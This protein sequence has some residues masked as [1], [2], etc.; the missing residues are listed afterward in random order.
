MSG[1][2]IDGAWVE[3]GGPEL[4]SVDPAT[5]ISVWSDRSATKA[6]VELA[7]RAAREA[8]EGWRTKPFEERVAVAREFGRLVEESR[9]TVS[10]LISVETGKPRWESLTEV[11]SMVA[12]VDVSIASYR[13]RTGTRETE[14][15]GFRSVVRH[16]PHGVMG[17]LGP[18]NFPGHLP[19]GHIVPALLA[20][21]TVV[22]KPSEHVPATAIA[23]VE[24][25]EQAG[26]PPGVLN[27]VV[28]GRD[29]GASLVD[30]PYLDGLL[31]TGSAAVGHRLHR[32][33]AHRPETIL[34]LEM[35]GNNPLV[36]DEIEAVEAGLSIVLQSAY[37]TAGQRCT[38][39][40]RLLVPR[41]PFGSRFIDELVEATRRLR[42]G[43]FDDSAEPFMG[44]VI[45]SAA[46]DQLVEA[47]AGL[48]RL[49]AVPMLEMR[50]LREGTGFVS[51]A[52]IDVSAVSSL[53]DE[54][55]FGPLLQV[56]Y[57]D[58]FEEAIR[59]SNETRF[60][61]AAGLVSHDRTKWEAFLASVR[62]G[63]VNWNRPLTGAS[64][65]APFG[66]VGASGNHR[67]SA[68]YAADYCA[69]PVS[70]LEDDSLRL[71]ETLPPGMTL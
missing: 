7:V 47:Q 67:P 35:G 58:D 27:L 3:G 40:R 25:W 32:E 11:A 69:Y 19:N 17:V 65:A 51:P 14:L 55:H 56:R 64:S 38:C 36:V 52:V 2:F 33:L 45:S 66:G 20:G 41:G 6:E 18:Y 12:K 61:L 62:A 31:F 23:M 26:L 30:D 39:A 37:I 44:P 13:E 28:G 24:L 1:L 49:G 5:G 71:P 8:L 21:N 15:A 46:A 4:V 48:V 43:A 22:F 54:E 70:S 34:A 10:E 50:K 9:S 16:Q 68:Y 57:Y 29:V 42:I 60:G 63:V 53:P 59:L